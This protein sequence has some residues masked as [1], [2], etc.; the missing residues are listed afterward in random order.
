MDTLI[1]ELLSGQLRVRGGSRVDD[2]ALDVCNV[3]EQREDLE[4]VDELERCV[5]AALDVEGEDGSAAVREVL[6]VQS[7]IRVLRQRRMINVLDLRMVLEEFNDLFGVLDMALDAQRQRLG[8]LQ[9]Q[10]SVERRDG[11]AGVAE[12][13]R[14]DIGYES[15]RADS[16]R[17][18]DAVVARVR[19]SDRSVLA[20]SLPVE[21]AGI[22]D[23]AAEGRA[24]T[25]DELGCGM[26]ND[27][28]TVLDRT[29][30]V[31]SAEGV[32]DDER[33]AVLVRDL[34]DLLDVRNVGVRVAEGLDVDSLGVVLDRALELCEVVRV[35]EGGLDAELGQGVREQ[36]VAAA[37]DGLLRYDVVA[38]LSERLNGVADR[39]CTG[40]GCQSCDA[41]LESCNAL[42]ENVLRGVGQT[43]VDVACVGKTETV[44]RVLAVM[45]NVRGGLINRNCA[46]VGYRVRLL[47]TDVKLL[48]FKCPIC[49]VLDL[50]HDNDLLY[51]SVS[52]FFL[53]YCPVHE[54]PG[55]VGSQERITFVRNGNWHAAAFR[56]SIA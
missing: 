21:L 9:E 48:G 17:E 30:E 54:P 32:V 51:I 45:E 12:K 6:L 50:C 55:A 28:S 38:C 26:Y 15:S 47:L 53:F 19:V 16:V 52:V 27:V 40:G 5:L 22:D 2:Q 10:E 42:L 43:A 24:V 44:G 3:R 20:G 8:A 4:L 18:G 49:G 1:L 34:S 23:N 13:D 39:C 7:V 14:A 37:V 31:R 46:G 25:A 35:N 33:Q 11:S 41:A 36:V 56:S 29:D